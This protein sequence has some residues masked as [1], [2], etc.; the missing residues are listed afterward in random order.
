[1]E[2]EDKGED[3]EGGVDGRG[4]KE[5]EFKCTGRLEIEPN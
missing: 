3:E 5:A 2:V 4:W 1:M